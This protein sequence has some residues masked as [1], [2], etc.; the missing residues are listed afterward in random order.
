MYIKPVQGRQVPDPDKGGFVPPEGREVTPH[1]YW[2]RRLNDGDVIE[3]E[4]P[5]SKKER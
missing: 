3:T 5:K 2:L 4:P 1:Q